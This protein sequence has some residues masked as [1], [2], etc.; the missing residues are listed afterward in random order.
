[1]HKKLFNLFFLIIEHWVEQ[2]K[3][4]ESKECDYSHKIDKLDSAQNSIYVNYC[5]LESQISP[6]NATLYLKLT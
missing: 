1:M 6:L 4:F 2:K 5:S 3:E